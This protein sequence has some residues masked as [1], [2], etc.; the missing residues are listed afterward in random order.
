MPNYQNSKVYKIW[1]DCND[2]VYVG[3]TTQPLSKRWFEHKKFCNFQPNRKIYKAMNELGIEKFHIELIK[4]FPCTCREELS[5]EEGR[6]IRNLDSINHGYNSNV[7]GRSIKQYYT[8]NKEEILQQQKQYKEQ[9]KQKI[10]EQH[11]QKS[12]CKFCNKT[13]TKHNM[14]THLKTCKQVPEQPVVEI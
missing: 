10:A 11:K 3:S 14:S 2:M 13:I 7:A 12:T 5:A 4:L 1:N 8:D 6:T 9:N